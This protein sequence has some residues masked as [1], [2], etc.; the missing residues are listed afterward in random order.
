MV[1]P[2]ASDTE[3]SLYFEIP[4]IPWILDQFQGKGQIRI[5]FSHSCQWLDEPIDPKTRSKILLTIT[6]K[7][8]D[9]FKHDLAAFRSSQSPIPWRPWIQG[10][11]NSGTW[12]EMGVRLASGK[13]RCAHILFVMI[14]SRN[15]NAW[16]ESEI[17]TRHRAQL[18]HT[19]NTLKIQGTAKIQGIYKVWGQTK[20]NIFP[21]ALGG[22]ST[23]KHHERVRR[24]GRFAVDFAHYIWN[25]R[26]RQP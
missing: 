25:S 5:R 18:R 22:K 8:V 13:F 12:H 11:P 15:R 6:K 23:G 24:C 19:L 16:C 10:T 9:I 17:W 2:V 1:L 26:F 3:F 4:L 14:L 7:T 20:K 21:A